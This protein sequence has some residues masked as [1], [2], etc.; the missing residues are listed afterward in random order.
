LAQNRGA[1]GHLKQRLAGNRDKCRLFDT[2]KLVAE[3]EDAF[4]AMHAD[5]RAGCLPVPNLDNIAVYHEIGVALSAGE[6]DDEAYLGVYAHEMARRDAISPLRAD[7]RAWAGR[8]QESV[9]T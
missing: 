5:Y 7:G 8:A 3:L 4:R 1:L 6:L 9:P 2:P